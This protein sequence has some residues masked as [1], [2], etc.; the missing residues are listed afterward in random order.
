MTNGISRPHGAR[1]AQ[2]NSQGALG[3]DMAMALVLA[4]Y[5]GNYH[6]PFWYRSYVSAYGVALWAKKRLQGKVTI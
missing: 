2:D 4:G 1:P 5:L 3:D 6:S